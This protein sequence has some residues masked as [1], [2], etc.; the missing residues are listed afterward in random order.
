MPV[1]I[2]A[3][4]CMLGRLLVELDRGRP[5]FK[6]GIDI[7]ESCAACS[8][9]AAPA[10]LAAITP[11]TLAAGRAGIAAGAELSGAV[12]TVGGGAAVAGVPAA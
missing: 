2:S 1:D 10:A 7:D 4:V 12:W 11:A 8:A 6:C 5:C 3:C 9:V